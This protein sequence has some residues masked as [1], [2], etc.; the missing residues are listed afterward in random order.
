LCKS[1]ICLSPNGRDSFREDADHAEQRGVLAQ[2]HIE[3]A[4]V[5]AP[6]HHFAYFGDAVVSGVVQQ[7]LYVDDVLALQDR[8]QQPAGRGRE[9]GPPPVSLPDL[10]VSVHRR[11]DVEE[12]AVVPQKV[13]E[14]RAAQPQRLVKHR[15]EHGGK[16]AGRGINDAQDLGRR[17]LLLQGIREFRGPL[18]KLRSAHGKLALEIGDDLLWISC[19]TMG[20]WAHLRT[21]T[22]R[23]FSQIIPPPLLATTLFSIRTVR[24]GR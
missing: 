24:G 1:A 5:A 4:A 22:D 9:R 17:G 21:S 13:A 20:R 18:I 2:S 12:L 14:I 3:Q 11:G 15:V 23:L 8:V 7:I 10:P 16:I 6:V 19:R